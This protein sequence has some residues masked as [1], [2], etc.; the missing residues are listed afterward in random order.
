MVSEIKTEIIKFQKSVV[1]L[2]S[3][4]KQV[5]HILLIEKK[6]KYFIGM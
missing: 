2:K 1:T 5:R 6:E 4:N 3:C